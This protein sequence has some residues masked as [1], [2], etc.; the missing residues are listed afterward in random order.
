MAIEIDYEPRLAAQGTPSVD[1]G[2]P[3]PRRSQMNA[4][5]YLL[6]V[7]DPEKVAIESADG[8][9]TYDQLRDRVAR[10][11]AAWRALGLGEGD[12]VLVLAPDS[13]SWVVA[14]LGAIWAGGVAVGL[15]SRLFE[16]DLSVIVA[17]SGARFAWCS[18]DTVTL[19][20]Q[21]VRAASSGPE[22]VTERQFET[23]IDRQG[24]LSVAERD[25]DDPAF[26]IYTSG[27]TGLP[28]GVVHAHRCV[29]AA[30][31]IAAEVIGAGREDR[32]Y[33]SSKLF[34]AYAHANSMC[35]GLRS[36]ATVILDREWATPERVVEIVA[37]HRPTVA[38]IVP[39]LYLKLLQA[40]LAPQ[41]RDVRHFVSAG[42]K[43]PAAIRSAWLEATGSGIIDGYGTSETN[44]LMLY[45]PDGSGVLRPSPRAEVRW[46]EAPTDKPS[47]IW[48]KH[49]SAAI[50][51][52]GRPDATA[53]CFQAGSF[54]PGDLFLDAG[55]GRFDIRGR[56]DDLLKIAGQWVS[57]ADVDAALM[58]T[59]GESVKEIG[60][61]AYTTAA[62]LG[63]LAVF[64]VPTDSEREHAA[65]AL[66]AA[67]E[68]LPRQRRPREIHWVD[69]LPRT[70]TGKLQRNKLLGSR[71]A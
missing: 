23:L 48:I 17:E 37:R 51:Y 20:E 3:P 18:P 21:C 7:G 19:F 47:R 1:L 44:F 14:Y 46:R 58:S 16:R 65:A 41:L 56:N 9:I 52:W 6:E 55:D 63:A 12:R 33:S 62:G 68:R 54:S 34:F 67:I 2:P 66:D 45:D 43:L 40:G 10:A 26:W 71:A 70:T 13:I 35:A 31:D 32:F 29:W 49:T 57:V 38:F 39:T 15:N 69:T 60:T 64:A 22:V 11:A 50:G 59:C 61:V 27:T 53:E 8:S 4:A 36:G 30:T 5:A 28:K 25:A 24:P 42:E